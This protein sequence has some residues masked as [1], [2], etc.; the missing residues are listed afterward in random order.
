MGA[1]SL[2]I[3]FSPLK[4]LQPGQ[5]CVCAKE[6]AQFYTM[7][8]R[9]YWRATP[10]LTGASPLMEFFSDLFWLV[11]LLQPF[12]W[13]IY[14]FIVMMAFSRPCCCVIIKISWPSFSYTAASL[15]PRPTSWTQTNVKSLLQLT[16]EQ[17][18]FGQFK[19]S[20]LAA[21]LSQEHCKYSGLTCHW[22]SSLLLADVCWSSFT[23]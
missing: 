15:I 18:C 12:E 3:P 2:C 10:W 6:P 9:S 14:I 19:H 7:F 8:G 22:P 21:K 20:F 4:T 11:V 16:G 1:K 5:M 17:I 13:G 23:H